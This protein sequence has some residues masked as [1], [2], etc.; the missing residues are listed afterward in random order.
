VGEEI[1]KGETFLGGW[2]WEEK[3]NFKNWGEG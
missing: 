1:F 2:V 3:H